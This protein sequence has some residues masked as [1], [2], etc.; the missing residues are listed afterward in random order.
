LI[1]ITALELIASGVNDQAFVH[2]QNIACALRQ[3]R[4]LATIHDGSDKMCP[5]ATW[6]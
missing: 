6:P 1:D 4:V 2:A 5:Q 3:V